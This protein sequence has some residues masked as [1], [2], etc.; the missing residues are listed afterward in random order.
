MLTAAGALAA[1][2]DTA[3]SPRPA[4]AR[5]RLA[6]S[7]EQ[8]LLDN[9]G[10]SR[11]GRGRP[12]KTDSV[13]TKDF[14]VDPTVASQIRLGDHLVSFPANSIC[15]PATSGYG[16]TLWD[17]PCTPLQQPITIHATWQSKLGHAF[18]QFSPDIRFVPTSDPSQYVTITMKDLV[19]LDSTGHYPIFWLRP[20]DSTFVDESMADSS[21]SSVMDLDGNKVSRRLKHFSGYL[22]GAT[23]VCDASLD[24]SCVSVLSFSGYLV[25]Y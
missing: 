14:V 24:S 18:I 8:W 4:A 23:E 2:A 17:A 11:D 7:Y 15:D 1:C 9:G 10:L 22:V 25:G 16:E 3:T 19:P 5:P 13:W 21:E 20:S 6:N 12:N